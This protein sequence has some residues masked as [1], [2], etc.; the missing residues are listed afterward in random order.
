MS[1]ANQPP[2]TVAD[3]LEQ[4]FELRRHPS[5]RRYSY[6]EIALAMRTRSRTYGFQYVQQLHAGKI[7]NPGRDA[8]LGLCLAF[9]V[10]PAYFFP[11]L[12]EEDFEPL[13]G[14]E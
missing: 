7:T 11:E 12:A 2:P 3:L 14:Q 5:G 8:L 9:R 13:P 6:R 1:N 4:L 10:P